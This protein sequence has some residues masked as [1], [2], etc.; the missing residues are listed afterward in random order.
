MAWDRGQVLWYQSLCTLWFLEFLGWGTKEMTW[1]WEDVET[2]GWACQR[3]R[4]R[5]SWRGR[6]LLSGWHAPSSW[7]GSLLSSC[8]HLP[9]RLV[10]S[11]PAFLCEKSQSYLWGF[12]IFKDLSQLKHQYVIF[13]SRQGT[14]SPSGTALLIRSVTQGC[15]FSGGSTATNST[16]K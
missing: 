3:L 2:Q 1:I 16:Q 6:N 7:A 10:H 8:T 15:E 9:G 5:C 11:V 4:V 13:H 14:P 12:L